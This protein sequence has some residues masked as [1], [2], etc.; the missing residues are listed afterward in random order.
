[1][2]SYLS[3]EVVESQ[4][5]CQQVTNFKQGC[6]IEI[7]L[8]VETPQPTGCF[9]WLELTFEMTMFGWT[10]AGSWSMGCLEN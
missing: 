10:L 7:T 5:Q 2:T 3:P 9:A 8:E 6:S 4:V 1:M